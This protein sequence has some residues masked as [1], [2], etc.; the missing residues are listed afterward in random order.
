MNM[1][2]LPPLGSPQGGILT[3]VLSEAQPLCKAPWRGLWG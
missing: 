1:V 2:A 3:L